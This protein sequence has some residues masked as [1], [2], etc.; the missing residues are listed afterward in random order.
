VQLVVVNP[1]IINTNSNSKTIHMNKCSHMIA[2]SRLGHP[3][4]EYYDIMLIH[5]MSEGLQSLGDFDRHVGTPCHDCPH[6]WART[7]TSCIA[8]I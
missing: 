4:D 8:H 1:P 5:N 6:T 7:R 3:N 2:H